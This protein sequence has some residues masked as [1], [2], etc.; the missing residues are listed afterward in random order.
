MVFAILAGLMNMPGFYTRDF[1]API[2]ADGQ[3]GIQ[4]VLAN[5]LLSSMVALGF[6]AVIITCSV[7]SRRPMMVDLKLDKFGQKS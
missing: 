6:I 2:M 7:V 1:W 5:P 4:W 3:S